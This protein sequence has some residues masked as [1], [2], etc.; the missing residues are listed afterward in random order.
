MEI[1]PHEK[2]KFVYRPSVSNLRITILTL[3]LT[4]TCDNILFVAGF[5]PA[6]GLFRDLISA[7]QFKRSGILM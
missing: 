1:V 6:K 3:K 7:W 5:V 4:V 2:K